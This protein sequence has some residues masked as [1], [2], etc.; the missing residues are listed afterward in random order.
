M[1][2]QKEA[3]EAA[4]EHGRGGKFS[5]GALEV[6][7]KTWDISSSPSSVTTKSNRTPI[8]TMVYGQQQYPR[9]AIQVHTYAYLNTT[10]DNDPPSGPLPSD[11]DTIILYTPTNQPTQQGLQ[12]EIINYFVALLISSYLI[13]F[14]F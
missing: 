3:K 7:T 11:I 10:T 12:N 4:A 14:Y 9:P 5:K 13:L 6:T 2:P 8:P 1:H